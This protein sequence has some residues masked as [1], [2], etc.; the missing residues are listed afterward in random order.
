[1]PK[2]LFVCLQATHLFFP[3]VDDVFGGAEVSTAR[4]VQEL[5]KS[6]DL[7]IHVLVRKAGEPCRE[8]RGPL[9]VH[10]FDDRPRL[11]RWAPMV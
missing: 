11:V 1:M 2:V 5:A 9:V 10:A 3:E 8:S 6:P 7:S 4:L